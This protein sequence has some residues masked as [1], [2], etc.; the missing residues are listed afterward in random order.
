MAVLYHSC[1]M[2]HSGKAQLQNVPPQYSL[3]SC[4]QRCCQAVVARAAVAGLQQPAY[5]TCAAVPADEVRSNISSTGSGSSNSGS[6]SSSSRRPEGV[7]PVNGNSGG[8]SSRMRRAESVLPAQD[9]LSPQALTIKLQQAQS[10]QQLQQLWECNCQQFNTYHYSAVMQQLATLHQAVA[11]GIMLAGG[12]QQRAA[13][14]A[15]LGQ[16]AHLL[17]SGHSNSEVQAQV[18]QLARRVAAAALSVGTRQGLD[19]RCLVMMSVNL[20]KVGV[21]D[22]QLHAPLRDS[23]GPQVLPQLDAQQLTNLIWAV[24]TCAA[25]GAVGANGSSMAPGKRG[26]YSTA[27]TQQTSSSGSSS[28]SSISWR[29]KQ[30]M[31]WLHAAAGQL[32][33]MLPCCS[34]AGVAMAVWGFAQAGFN[35]GAAWWEAFWVATQPVLQSYSAQNLA[36]LACALGKLQVQVSTAGCL[37]S[38]PWR[39]Y[40]I[41]AG[42]RWEGAPALGAVAADLMSTY[43]VPRALTQP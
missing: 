25:S 28:G 32:R 15:Q 22:Q 34:D 31:P 13:S 6:E 3:L 9:G 35:P 40:P 7:L 33:V 10:V 2:L 29:A 17:L 43:M 20:V 30:P 8:S 18:Q 5:T 19:L 36:L 24:G 37:L 41:R 42:R 27:S 38:S 14:Q 4:C 16:V 23:L 21:F 39:M 12:K 11:S 1:Y 26:I